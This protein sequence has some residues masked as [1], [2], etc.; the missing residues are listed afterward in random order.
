MKSTFLGLVL[1][2]MA[3]LTSLV[4]CASAAPG[5]NITF[6][7]VRAAGA[8]CLS[9]KARG[10]VTVS[11]LGPVQNMHV[12]LFGLTPNNDFT[13][14]ITEHS[15][16]PF[17]LTWY[18]GEI[19]TDKRGKGVG[20]FTGIF[21]A[22]TFVFDNVTGGN[23]ATQLSHVALWF[24]DPNDAATAGCSGITTPFD[25]DHVAGILVLS[26]ENFPDAK[27]PLQKLGDSQ[28]DDEE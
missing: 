7:L 11:D 3:G 12:E 21:S 26:S 27:G 18:Q 2:T 16:R 1:T 24:A 19:T 22:E 5:D 14:F 28:D 9:S 23:T 10:R 25:G 17:G 8:T 15:T 4:P 13:L 20:D 6:N